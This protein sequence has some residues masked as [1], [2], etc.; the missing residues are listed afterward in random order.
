VPNEK[1]SENRLR[2]IQK[3]FSEGI[4]EHCSGVM[5]LQIVFIVFGGKSHVS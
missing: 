2:A 1:F 3:I 5:S 4:A